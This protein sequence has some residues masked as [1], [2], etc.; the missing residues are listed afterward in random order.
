M[1][2][3]ISGAEYGIRGFIDAYDAKTFK[4]VWRF[5]TVPSADD[6]SDH[7]RKALASWEG[8]S[9]LT[10]GGS[11]W[12]TGTYDPELNTLYWGIGNP[13]PDFNG[14]VRK[15]DNL[16]TC[17]I[18]A[19][20]PDD[21][22]YKWH[23]QNSPHDVWDYDGV[24]EPVL[25]DINRD[26]R[27]IKALVQAHRNGYFYCLNRETG[28]F[29]YGKPFCEVTWTDRTK[30]VDGLDPKTGRPF[31]SPSALPTAEGSRV[32]PGPAGGKEWCPIAYD[33]ANGNAIVPVIN[34]FAKVTSGKAFFI[35]GQ[36]YWGSAMTLIDNQ[37]SGSL[38]AIDVATGQIKWQVSTRSPMVAGVL[39]TAGGLVFTGD[40]E[41][42]F[43]A[44][45]ATTG[46]D[47]WT[48]QCG[49]GHHSVRSPTPSTAGSTSPSA[50][51]GAAGR[52][53]SP[54]TAPVAPQRAA[55]QYPVCLRVARGEEVIHSGKWQVASGKWRVAWNAGLLLMLCRGSFALR[56]RRS[57]RRR[58]RTRAHADHA[59]GR[60][61]KALVICGVPAS[62][63]RTDRTPDG[64]PRGLDAVVAER[65]GRVLGRPVEFHWCANAGCSWHCLPEGRCDVVAGQPIDSGPPRGVAWSVPYAGARFGL[66]VP[67]DQKGIRS[68]DDL[69]GRRIGIVAGT[70][71][72]AEKD[73]SIVR[74][75]SREELLDRF[76][77]AKLD[78]AFLD[79]DFAA[80]YLHEHPKFPLR[81]IDAFVPRERWNM[82]LAV[83]AGDADL[84]VAINRALAQLA[85][86]GE[87]RKIYD[88]YGVPF[89][90]PFTATD[91][92]AEVP[93][94]WPRIRERGEI[95]VSMDPANL[96]YSSARDERPGFDVELARALADRLHLKLRIDW[97][98]IHRDTALGALL[99]GRCDLAFGDPVDPDAVAGDEPTAEKIL[100]SRPYYAT[101]YSLVR[102]K[103]GP[104]ARSLAELKGD[105][106]RRLGAEA[107]S[108]AD[109]RLAQRGYVRRLYRNQLAAL[110]ALADGDID[111][112]YLWAN[113]GWTLN[114]SPDLAAKLQIVPGI[115]REDRWDIAV[116][117][118]RGD[119]ELKRQVD[120][121]IG[122]LVADGTVAGTLARYHVPDPARP[123]KP[124]L[125]TIQTS[126]RPYGALDRI[127]S[128]GE[129]VVGLD[130]NNLPF[131]TAHPA[132][133]G[134]DYEVAGLLAE[135]LG[136]S[137]RIY[138]AVAAH[139]SY[140]SKLATKKLC[141]VILGVSPDDRFGQR[142]LYSRP[143]HVA[144]YRVVVRAARAGP[145]IRSRWPSRR[146][147]PCGG[148]RPAL[149]TRIR[150]PR[151]SSRP[152]RPAASGRAMRSRPAAPGWPTSDGRASWIGCPRPAPRPRL[153]RFPSSRPCGSRTSS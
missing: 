40:A 83:R 72:L 18:L 84:L 6:K 126:K 146:A 129:L 67:H 69:R 37:A 47:L 93:S 92:R 130:Q 3:G 23:F 135:R 142:V 75:K 128:A 5:Y 115:E 61:T 122:A 11:A 90:A 2:I 44:Y 95:V 153:T 1:I 73:H 105:R 33:E 55:R 56:V 35:K 30:G 49:S 119:R 104:R 111:F 63:P 51:A 7:A 107:G 117:M 94:S 114:A 28:E 86:S 58:P 124:D 24:N 8:N 148:S 120:A 103:D 43:T 13:S 121:A 100:H 19:I 45:E 12:V 89:H 139:D 138:W 110:K 41:G 54:A 68:L 48:F 108:V 66:V 143:Y 152:W 62:M 26:G 82:A 102:R 140:P 78:A 137:L 91:R 76:I 134:L 97:L 87:L 99:E 4:R 113:A 125:R 64:T 32:C 123:G 79:A 70:V 20:N 31:V 38:K 136:V 145:W 131:S 149:S 60:S 98:D 50:S 116:A 77:D 88:E 34:N 150:A 21:G 27:K 118:R 59:V 10:G 39:A 141:D 101:G 53:G 133:A 9:W 96:P 112:A 132:P 65:V 147:S 52:P 144:R 29:L 16:Y 25:V 42:N 14:E 74:F 46:K 15:G 106:S 151:R 85:E 36:P 17:S 71:A 22:S 127:R 80:W 57:R 81:L 109:Y